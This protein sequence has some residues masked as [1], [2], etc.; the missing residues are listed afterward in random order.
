MPRSGYVYIMTNA[1]HTVLYTGVTSDLKGRVYK[2][3]EGSIPGFTKRYNAHILVYFEACGEMPHA[4]QREKQIK[5]WSR[6][7]KND[8]IRS[9]NPKWQD[10]YESI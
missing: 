6:R 4:I 7:R 1:H 9:L 5:S 3:R 10:L 2:H 8:L